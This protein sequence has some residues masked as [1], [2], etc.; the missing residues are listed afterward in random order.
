MSFFRIGR[1]QI[2][3]FTI[4]TNPR[5]SFVSSSVSGATGSVFI[6]PRRSAVQK[7][8]DPVSAFVDATSNES[9]PQAILASIQGTTSSDV[10]GKLLSYMDAVHADAAPARLQERLEIVRF[11]PSFQ[12][13]SDTTSK[14]YIKNQ[15]MPYWRAARPSYGWFTTNFNSLNFFTASSVPSNTVLLYPNVVPN[16]LPSTSAS[17]NL[18]GAF[19][20]EGYINPRYTTDPGGGFKAGTILHLSSTFALSLMTGS[21]V[22]ENGFANGFRLLLQLSSSADSAPSS[23]ILGTRPNDLIFSSSDNSLVR[24][25]WHHFVV[26][27]GS[28]STNSGT[29]SFVV[30]GIPAG[31]FVVPSSS[32][33]STAG[34]VPGVLCLG[35]FYEGSN[36]GNDAQSLFFAADPA[37][38]DGLIQ[39]DSTTG[40]DAPG[41]FAFK[42]PLNAELHDVALH[43][44]YLTD[45]DIQ[46]R[47]NRGIHDFTDVLFYVPPFFTRESPTRKFVGNLGGVPTT[48]FFTRDDT[49][50]D[51]FNVDLSFGVGGHYL[52]LENYTK[53]FASLVFP[54]LLH[55]TMSVLTTTTSEFSAN[56][57]LYSSPSVVKRNLT[58]LPCD[59]GAFVP[60]FGV[61]GTFLSGSDRM[62]DPVGAF[63]PSIVTLDN[64]LSGV[65]TYDALLETDS[66]SLFD[67]IVG[68]SPEPGFIHLKGRTN[69]PDRT[70]TIYQRTRDASSNEVTM[71]NVRSLFYGSRIDPGS[72]SVTDTAVSASDGKIKITLSDDGYGNLFRSDAD[73]PHPTWSTVGNVLYE[74]GL[75]VV[76]TPLVPFFGKDQFS[77]AFRGEQEVNV[78]K[79]NVLA[80]PSTLNSSSNVTYVPVSASFSVDDDDQKFVYIT[81][82]NLHDRDLNVV[83]KAQLAQPVI[84]R[85]RGKILFRLRYDF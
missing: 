85:S 79:V 20:I 6:F 57:Y 70:L 56:D 10:H 7:D 80:S 52:N 23:A 1:D 8:V 63:D 39:L 9:T 58:I 78:M 66:G 47:R 71:F 31:T 36:S 45:S 13:S 5:Q 22:D 26:R 64:L 37:A 55:L 11:V 16:G 25:R 24:N 60:N 14:L 51:P 69:T 28:S 44:R 50:I 18:T 33:A 29:G 68:P 81:G 15:L 2:E 72:F 17:Y 74:D 76:K 41:A 54:R 40:V 35:N 82:I 59:D 3:N 4:V 30:N 48:P 42:H 62:L 84:K 21:S 61:L 34:A 27:W 49:T 43:Q 38:R 77:M 32:I 65:L 83:M 19:S 67:A 46:Q 75:V 53:D 12:F 73:G